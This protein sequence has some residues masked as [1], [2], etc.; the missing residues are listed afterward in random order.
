MYYSVYRE[1]VR[2]I[3]HQNGKFQIHFKGIKQQQKKIKKNEKKNL[4]SWKVKHKL[5]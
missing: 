4:N 2:F 3:E 1:R 5:F